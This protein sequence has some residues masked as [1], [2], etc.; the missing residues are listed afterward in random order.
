MAAELQKYLKNQCIA[1]TFNL[2]PQTPMDYIKIKSKT[3]TEISTFNTHNLKAVK[4]WARFCKMRFDCTLSITNQPKPKAKSVRHCWLNGHKKLV[5]NV[6]YN[7]TPL[8]FWGVHQIVWH[9]ICYV[10]FTKQCK[11]AVPTR[12]KSYGIYCCILFFTWKL[13]SKNKA[14]TATGK[15]P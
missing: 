14:T 1:Q 13:F 4:E 8:C 2:E 5:E 7:V 15:K 10:S 3:L 12:L 11:Y 6:P 9:L